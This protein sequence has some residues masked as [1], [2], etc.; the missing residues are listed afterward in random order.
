MV[1]ATG[2]PRITEGDRGP[3]YLVS[4][5]G[6]LLLLSC[7]PRGVCYASEVGLLA[8]QGDGC[9]D[10]ALACSQSWRNRGHL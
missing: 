4:Q 10:V 2:I 9:G 1:V 8:V 3:Y 5:R 7:H 6:L